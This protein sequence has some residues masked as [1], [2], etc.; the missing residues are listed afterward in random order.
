MA[1]R[2]LA[3]FSRCYRKESFRGTERFTTS[4]ASIAQNGKNHIL[5]IRQLLGLFLLKEQAVHTA[6]ELRTSKRHYQL[7]RGLLKAAGLEDKMKYK[8]NNQE[9]CIINPDNGARIDFISRT[10]NGGRGLAKID[11]VYFDEALLL[12]EEQVA[13]I[14][15]TQSARSM[16]GHVQTW[17]TSSAGKLASEVLAEI[18]NTCITQPAGWCYYEWSAKAGAD[19]TD[20]KEWAAA[21]PA[22]NYT[23]ADGSGLSESWVRS[24]LA[25][26]PNKFGRERLGIWDEAKANT[27]IAGGLWM[28]GD[29]DIDDIP[30]NDE[31]VLGIEVGNDER[32]VSIA[33]ATEYQ[34]VQTFSQVLA[35]AEGFNWVAEYIKSLKLSHN[36]RS[37]VTDSS[38]YVL[39]LLPELMKAGIKL[40]QLSTT[41]AATACAN[42]LAGVHAKTIRHTDDEATR[43]TVTSAG[44]RLSGEKWYWK[45]TTDIDVAPLKAM[46]WAAYGLTMNQSKQTKVVKAAPVLMV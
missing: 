35:S 10:N 29:L 27:V 30:V 7:V 38:G 33:L 44:K 21:N 28:E 32:T 31:I 43:L 46:T 40:E 5:A 34:G 41:Q 37:V 45:A 14:L 26:M 3:R 23:R 25:K 4:A 13:S 2:H 11:V 20:P 19:I 18:R 15:S 17:Y 42:Y 36:V 22:Y 24:E 16:S 12:E 6:H 39:G 9:I 8:E 1:R